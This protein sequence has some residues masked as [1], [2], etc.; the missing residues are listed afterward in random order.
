MINQA[1]RST[2]TVH[3]QRDDVAHT[4]VELLHAFQVH[5]T[6]LLASIAQDF[7][8]NTV[9]A[10][11]FG[12]GICVTRWGSLVRLL[13]RGTQALTRIEKKRMES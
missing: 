7:A 1:N 13:R 4:L 3:D 8:G 12:C 6:P 9:T 10:S 2:C 11:C 5:D